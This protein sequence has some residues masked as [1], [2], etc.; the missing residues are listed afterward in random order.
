[1]ILEIDTSLLRKANIS[2]NQLVFLSL[3]LDNNQKHNQ[4]IVDIVSQVNDNE[5][6]DLVE[7]ELI[8]EEEM[9]GIKSYKETEKLLSLFGMDHDMFDD[10]D[11][12]YPKVVTRPD[13]TM[14]FL[15]GNRKK[16]RTK[17]NQIIKRSRLVHQHIID[18]LSYDLSKKTLTGKL[19]YMKTMW[20][21]LTQCEWEAIEDEMMYNKETETLET[22]GTNLL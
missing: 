20:M 21:W 3:V 19:G 6:Q 12:I 13:G 22:Y 7:K 8:V 9:N 17:Y 16:C 11:E 1:M 5:I 10:F 15:K 14:G 4:N 2:I 18:C